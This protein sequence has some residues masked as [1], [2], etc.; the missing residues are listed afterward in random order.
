MDEQKNNDFV[1]RTGELYVVFC[2]LRVMG[3]LIDDSGLDASFEE[4]GN[5]AILS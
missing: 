5:C 2:G 3:K 1:F 4:A